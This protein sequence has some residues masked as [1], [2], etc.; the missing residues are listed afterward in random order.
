MALKVDA[1]F[2]KGVF[3]PDQRPALAD[4]ERVRL[5]I[6]AAAA[7]PEKSAGSSLGG[8]P[9]N[10]GSRTGTHLA[11]ALDYHPDGC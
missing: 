11:I 6:E 1:S 3:V 9:I 2:E 7:S 4:R 5:T 8:D 10:R